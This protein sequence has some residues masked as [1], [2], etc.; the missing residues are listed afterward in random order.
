MED[1]S[2]GK[3]SENNSNDN[4]GNEKIE[5]ME[6]MVKNAMTFNKRKKVD[7]KEQ[8]E[9]VGKFWGNQPV[10]QFKGEEITESD[11]GPI[12]KNNDVEKEP[13]EN[14]I[15][16]KGYCWYD[17]DIHDEGDLTKV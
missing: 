4:N 15:L 13:K 16:P 14:T 9:R 1:T 12:D 5:E 2:K 8:M 17:I 11:I 3:K 6:R 7:E 10:P